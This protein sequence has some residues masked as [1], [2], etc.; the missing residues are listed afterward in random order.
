MNAETNVSGNFAGWRISSFLRGGG[1]GI[2]Q[3]GISTL[4]LPNLIWLVFRGL[5]ILSSSAAS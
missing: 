3:G 4:D 5:S 1:F 2:N